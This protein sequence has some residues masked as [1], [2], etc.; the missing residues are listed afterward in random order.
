[1]L[2]SNGPSSLPSVEPIYTGL[3]QPQL[4]VLA[5]ETRLYDVNRSWKDVAFHLGVQ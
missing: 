4:R 2:N 5:V 3:G 1:M